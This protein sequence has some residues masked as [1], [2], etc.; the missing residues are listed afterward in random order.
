MPQISFY[1]PDVKVEGANGAGPW[2]NIDTGVDE[3]GWGYSLNAVAF[4]T[5]GGEVVQILSCFLENLTIQGTVANYAKMEQIY[6]YFVYYLQIATQGR[7]TNSRAGTASYNQTPITCVYPERGWTFKIFITELPG[8]R[9]ATETVA[10]EWRLTAH[11]VDDSMDLH[12]IKEFTKSQVLDKFLA[13]DN[14]KFDTQGYIGFRAMN[15][16]SAPD[17]IF[18]TDFDLGETKEDWKKAGDRFAEVIENYLDSDIGKVREGLGSYPS[19]KSQQEAQESA[20][21]ALGE[22]EEET[23]KRER[24][25]KEKEDK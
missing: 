23:K 8:F 6:S 19:W 4:P 24:Q 22:T 21:K 13:G 16:F 15:P 11:I 3:I 25:E 14:E 10:P 7:K 20:V 2:L 1:H 9:Y 5:Y 18:G 17:T 12:D